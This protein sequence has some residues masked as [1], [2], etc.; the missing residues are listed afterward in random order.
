MTMSK[1]KSTIQCNYYLRR[2]MPNSEHSMAPHYLQI[3]TTTVSFGL[4]VLEVMHARGKLHCTQIKI[5]QKKH[6]HPHYS[7]YCTFTYV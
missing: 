6:N 2:M 1:M 7:H 4:S 3:Y 5:A